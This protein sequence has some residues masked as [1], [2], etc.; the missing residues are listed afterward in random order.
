MDTVKHPGAPPKKLASSA[1]LPSEE[2]KDPAMLQLVVDLT[3]LVAQL[4][5]RV[6]RLEAMAMPAVPALIQPPGF[7]ER[8][9]KRGRARRKK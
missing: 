5:A 8:D 2:V 6:S 4:A 9:V 7:L 1:R 3:E